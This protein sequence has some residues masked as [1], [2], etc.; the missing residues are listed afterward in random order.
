MECEVLVFGVTKKR[1]MADV[2][3]D[4]VLISD[5]PHPIA[6]SVAEDIAARER[7]AAATI[8]VDGLSL[9]AEGDDGVRENWKRGLVAVQ[10]APLGGGVISKSTSNQSG[11]RGPAEQGTAMHAS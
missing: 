1:V 8:T 10:S 2:P 3:I 5:A 6:A 11:G 9:A 7:W 4:P